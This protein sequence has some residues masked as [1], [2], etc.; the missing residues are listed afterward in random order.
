MN[1]Q[2]KGIPAA[3]IGPY[4]G[5]GLLHK[6][7]MSQVALA[8]YR[9]QWAHGTTSR[10]IGDG[11]TPSKTIDCITAQHQQR[12]AILH[13]AL[14]LVAAQYYVFKNQICHILNSDLPDDLHPTVTS[15]SGELI[16]YE[17]LRF[18]G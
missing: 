1:G 13:S 4:Y 16:N 11:F 6:H 8:L 15:R 12:V 9:W 3:E 18:L 2:H 14:S 7:L 10:K 5:D 17:Q